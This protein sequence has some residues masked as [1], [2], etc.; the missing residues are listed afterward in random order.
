[1]TILDRV[2][3]AQLLIDYIGIAYV[4]VCTAE[5]V[6]CL[7]VKFEQGI[8][9]VR[10]TSRQPLRVSIQGINIDNIISDLMDLREYA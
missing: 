4:L 2:A 10:F 7:W 3:D 5:C 8:T 1:M 9:L 6:D